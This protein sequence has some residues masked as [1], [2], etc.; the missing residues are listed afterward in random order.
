MKNRLTIAADYTI[1]PIQRIGKS[2]EIARSASSRQ[3][4]R[5]RMSAVRNLQSLAEPAAGVIIAHCP[6]SRRA[7]SGLQE[8]G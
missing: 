1:Q 6:E 5:H 8:D 2:H 4:M 3:A 7:P